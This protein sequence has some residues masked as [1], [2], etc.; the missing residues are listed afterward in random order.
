[1]DTEQM[2]DI[3]L[4]CHETQAFEINRTELKRG[5]F[6]D[7][8]I[9]YSGD[10]YNEESYPHWK[11]WKRYLELLRP[12][13]KTI[14]TV[15]AIDGDR[16]FSKIEIYASSEVPTGQEDYKKYVSEHFSRCEKC[17]KLMKQKNEASD[18]VV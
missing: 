12:S 4:Q 11:Q 2:V 3:I 6:T 9:I 16:Y 8:V 1:M 7:E 14:H 17:A 5:I 10:R 18:V 13:D 15:I